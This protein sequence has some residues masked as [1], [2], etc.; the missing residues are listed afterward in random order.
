[1]RHRAC[2]C[3]LGA[4]DSN[5]ARQQVCGV[6]G[7]EGEGGVGIGRLRPPLGPPLVRVP[8]VGGHQRVVAAARVMDGHLDQRRCA[9]G[10]GCAARP[11]QLPSQLILPR[12]VGQA[13]DDA[14][15]GVA[16]AA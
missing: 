16:A 2:A 10:L 3:L 7:T 6:P 9:S 12:A 1:M 13:L 15:D 8:E 5:D 11:H 14:A 4:E